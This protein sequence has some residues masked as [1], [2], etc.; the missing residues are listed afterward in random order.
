VRRE[1]AVGVV[2]PLVR[3]E[4]I[5]QVTVPAQTLTEKINKIIKY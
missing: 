3:G 1:V 4:Q 5:K 2:Q